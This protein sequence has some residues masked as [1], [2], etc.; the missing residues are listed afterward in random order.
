MQWERVAG[1]FGSWSRVT[2]TLPAIISQIMESDQQNS[3][4]KGC[5]SSSF[6]FWPLLAGAFNASHTGVWL[7]C[8]VWFWHSEKGQGMLF[9]STTLLLFAPI[10]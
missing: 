10:L 4:N 2:V 7:D 9:G 3:R 8:C 5:F 6:S 1:V